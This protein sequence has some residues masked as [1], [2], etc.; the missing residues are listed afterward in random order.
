MRRRHPAPPLALDAID[1]A[2]GYR[3]PLA[4]ID[5]LHA[6]GEAYDE[7]LEHFATDA[8]V[9]ALWRTH[10]DFLMAEATRRG[11]APPVSRGAQ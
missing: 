2:L 7:W 6:A 3:R 8:D 5:A 4:E 11:I 1:V 9:D 10:A